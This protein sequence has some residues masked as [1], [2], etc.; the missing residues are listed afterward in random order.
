MRNYRL[1]LKF[2]SQ[3]WLD[4]DL[5]CVLMNQVDFLFNISAITVTIKHWAL[6]FKFTFLAVRLHLS[7]SS[8]KWMFFCNPKL[9]ILIV[10]KV[11]YFNHT[12]M[13]SRKSSAGTSEQFLFSNTSTFI[14]SPEIFFTSSNK[15][16][17]WYISPVS[18]WDFILMTIKANIFALSLTSIYMRLLMFE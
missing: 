1:G 5:N 6:F 17:N 18:S 15:S 11:K 2:S 3:L 14:N 7:V 10:K 9:H 13:S 4:C 16:N 12:E 8:L